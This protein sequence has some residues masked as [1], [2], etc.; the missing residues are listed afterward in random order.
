MHAQITI[1]VNSLRRCCY[2]ALTCLYICA[3]LCSYVHFTYTD[4]HFLLVYTP[5]CVQ[6]LKYMYLGICVCPHLA[7]VHVFACC[8][9]YFTWISFWDRWM[10]A[11]P[12]SFIW[13]PQSREREW[14]KMVYGWIGWM[15]GWDV[16]VLWHTPVNCRFLSFMNYSHT[17]SSLCSRYRF[18]W[19]SSHTSHFIFPFYIL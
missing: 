7:A 9:G 2:T 16:S 13:T 12:L 3:C 1:C 6:K 19:K 14:M 15:D 4:A 10:S 5:V 8:L 11:D 18:L 17:L